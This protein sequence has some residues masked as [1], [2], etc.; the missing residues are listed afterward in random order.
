MKKYIRLF[1][2]AALALLNMDLMQGSS[3]ISA[4]F[5]QNM[6]YYPGLEDKIKW[7]TGGDKGLF[8]FFG[9]TPDT[10]YTNGYKINI[11]SNSSHF[12]PF[13]HEVGHMRLKHEQ[14]SINDTKK[15]FSNFFGLLFASS[16]IS[17]CLGG[18]KWLILSPFVHTSYLRTYPYYKKLRAREQAADESV[19]NHLPIIY[20]LCSVFTTLTQ[21]SNTQ[22]E[23]H[24]YDDYPPIGQRIERFK[25]RSDNLAESILVH[26]SPEQIA[27]ACD[28][29]ENDILKITK[30]KKEI[31]DF[32]KTY[33]KIDGTS[34]VKAAKVLGIKPDR[35][36]SLEEDL[37]Q[38][39]AQ[40]HLNHVSSSKKN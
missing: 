18:Y 19:P 28:K 13:H 34:P 15:A 31:A 27:T 5:S 35:Y 16:Y 14:A 29:S 17:H 8:G 26:Y 24:W 9:K 12:A 6:K 22:T 4:R 7:Q 33:P 3:I 40:L 10:W 37:P 36:L 1:I 2:V 20:D 25:E 11:P 23:S 30:S 32:L 39:Y 21:N 38:S